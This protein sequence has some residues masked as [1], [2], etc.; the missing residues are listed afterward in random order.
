MTDRDEQNPLRLLSKSDL[1]DNL[2]GA[3]CAC[4]QADV[5]RE[6]LRRYDK[7]ATKKREP[8]G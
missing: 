8:A 7:A 4:G 1:Y 2:R 5:I 3:D 6:L